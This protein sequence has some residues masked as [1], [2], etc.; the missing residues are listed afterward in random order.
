MGQLTKDFKNA[1][2]PYDTLEFCF[3]TCVKCSHAAPYGFEVRNLALKLKRLGTTAI[4]L[5][6]VHT[7][8]NKKMKKIVK[9][10]KKND[11]D[12]KKK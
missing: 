7:P 10:M 1:W 11:K 12:C 6:S 8:L 2:C 4:R 5:S 3:L 9:K